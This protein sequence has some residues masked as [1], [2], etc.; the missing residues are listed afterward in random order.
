MKGDYQGVLAGRSGQLATEL[1]EHL[2][3]DEVLRTY[4]Q[5][6]ASLAPAGV[7]VARVPK[8][9]NLFG[10]HDRYGDFTESWFTAR[11]VAPWRWRWSPA[12]PRPTVMPCFPVAHGVVSAAGTVVRKLT[13][14]S[15]RLALAAET[16][17]LRGHI[18]TLSLAFVA[19]EAS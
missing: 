4:D 9:V 6:F 7:L 17:D 16:G 2:T 8:G 14:D 10:G 12:P 19:R 15:Y 5:A 11:K 1:L 3:K 18:L 13:N